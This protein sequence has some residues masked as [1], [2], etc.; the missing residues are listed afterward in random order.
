MGCDTC[1]FNLKALKDP[2]QG[3]M[4]NSQFALFSG[5]PFYCHTEDLKNCR[6]ANGKPVDCVSFVA[7]TKALKNKNLNVEQKKIWR[8][9]IK[10]S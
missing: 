9:M 4:G 3:A 7:F 2:T 5:G 6:M 10:N 8:L 1:G